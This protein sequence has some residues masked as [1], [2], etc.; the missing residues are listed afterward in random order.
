VIQ[1]L[2]SE[3]LNIGEVW[4]LQE[5]KW[6]FGAAPRTLVSGRFSP[7]IILQINL[8]LPLLCLLWEIF[9]LNHCYSQEDYCAD[10]KINTF[11]VLQKKKK[12]SVEEFWSRILHLLCRNRTQDYKWGSVLGFMFPV[13]CSIISLVLDMTWWKIDHGGD[14]YRQPFPALWASHPGTHGNIINPRSR[15]QEPKCIAVV[16]LTLRALSSS[17]LAI[18]FERKRKLKD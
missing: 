7:A 16:T 10:K 11:S 9:Q 4:R 15:A 6:L 13:C 17:C 5:R 3:V 18:F 12:W 14:W 2:A 1:W 8:S